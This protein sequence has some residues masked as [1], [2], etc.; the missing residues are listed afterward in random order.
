[1]N[2]ADNRPPWLAGALIMGA[3]AAAWAIEKPVR[4]N[5]SE[6]AAHSSFASRGSAAN[7]GG[8]LRPF[9]MPWAWWR[10]ILLNTYREIGDDRL[11]A[12]AAGVVFYALLA[13]FPAITAFVSFYGLFAD[14]STINDH[15]SL[16]SSILPSGA[17][18]ILQ[19]QIARI[20][21]NR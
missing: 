14:H 2:S 19:E 15:L 7:A 16:L 3:I 10:Q 1:M 6:A 12:V 21:A 11:L 18:G 20:V 13:T 8:A 9:Q 17:I 4:G 5:L